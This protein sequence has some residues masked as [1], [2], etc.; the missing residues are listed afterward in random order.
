MWMPHKDAQTACARATDGSP[1]RRLSKGLSIAPLFRRNNHNLSAWTSHVRY[2]QE[3]KDS[4]NTIDIS[5]NR[6]QARFEQLLTSREVASW[7]GVSDR[8]V[9]DHAT[10]RKPRI[11]SVCLS[12]L[13]R[14]RPEDIEAFIMAQRD[15][16]S[17][18][19]QKRYERVY[20]RTPR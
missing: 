2:R 18:S 16:A 1:Y 7:L 4:M 12:P 3:R 10:R 11:P 5:T 15:D 17:S 14:F 13:M 19:D 8:W 20:K 9:R 6:A